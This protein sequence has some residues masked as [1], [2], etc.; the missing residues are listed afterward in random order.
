MRVELHYCPG[1][2]TAPLFPP[3]PDLTL[4]RDRN[5][6]M[7]IEQT[8][9]CACSKLG[10]DAWLPSIGCYRYHQL[11]RTPKFLAEPLDLCVEIMGDAPQEIPQ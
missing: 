11:D 2:E 5:E 3:T 9:A 4:V 7:A 10:Q 1:K 6:S 8:V